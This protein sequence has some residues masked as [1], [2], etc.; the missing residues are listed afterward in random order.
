MLA[1]E[2]YQAFD[3]ELVMERQRAKQLCYEFNQLPPQDMDQRKACLHRLLR[4]SDAWVE[5]PFNV[6]YGYNIQVGRNFYANH[7]CTIL[8]CNAVIIG[9]GCLLGPNVCISAASH[10]L[11][12]ELR[13]SGLELTAPIKIGHNVWIGANASICPGVTIGNNVVVGAGAVVTKDIPDDV[14]V[15]GV[16]AK[17]IKPIDNTKT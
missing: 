8:D 6:D 11:E 12:A 17:V 7:G 15:G 13:T 5:S 9:D 16:P 14:L 2:L 3:D 4:V 1:G 10:P